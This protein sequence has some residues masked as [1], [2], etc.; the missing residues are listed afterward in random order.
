MYPYDPEKAKS[1]LEEAGWTDTDGDGIL[2]KDGQPLLLD[3][4]VHGSFPFYRD[5]GPIIQTQLE[6]I[7]IDVNLQGLAGPAWMEAGRTGNEHLG[8]VDWRSSDPE[9]NLRSA[10]H[11]ENTGAFAWN[12]HSNTHLDDLLDEAQITA[13]VQERCAIL[14]DV[15][16]IIMED[17]MVKPINLF[18]AVWGVRSEVKGIRISSLNPS[19][20]WAFDTYLEQ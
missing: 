8:I 6:E 18:S 5:P 12:H 19:T 3:F 11:S 2:D 20:F 15:Q 13:D 10:F 4:V 16:Q 1:L 14:E 9:R 17:A 7:G